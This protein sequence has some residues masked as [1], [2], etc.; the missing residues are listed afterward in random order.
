M[1]S[2]SFYVFFFFKQKTAYEMRISDWSSDVCSS[3]LQRDP[4]RTGIEPD[5]A[6][7]Q[8]GR[9]IAAGAA[10]KRAQTGDKL[11]GLERLG[12][13]IVRPGLKRSEERRVGKRVSVRVDL[14]GRRI[15]KKK[16]QKR[17]HTDTI[18]IKKLINRTQ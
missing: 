8:F 10:D 4:A 17:T 3:D 6:G 18:H 12:E 16:K 14:G 5:R 15:I 9:G 7:H 1:I 2:V 11:F 13:V